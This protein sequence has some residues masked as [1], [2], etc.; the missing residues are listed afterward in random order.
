MPSDWLQALLTLAT[1]TDE[2]L[3]GNAAPRELGL[4]L[5]CMAQVRGLLAINHNLP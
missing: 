2:M 1:C 3:E 4:A 5:A